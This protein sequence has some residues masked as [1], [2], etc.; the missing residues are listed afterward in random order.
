MVRCFTNWSFNN[1]FLRMIC[2][3]QFLLCFILIFNLLKHGSTLITHKL[4][5]CTTLIAIYGKLD[6]NTKLIAFDHF[7]NVWN[8]FLKYYSL[9]HSVILFRKKCFAH[10]RIVIFNF[11]FVEIHYPPRPSTRN[12]S[13]TDVCPKHFITSTN[14]GKPYSRKLV[15]KLV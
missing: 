3:F 9:K 7:T 13:Q 14:P 1:L 12:F 8:K 11:N 5:N 10:F 4:W 2:K 6:Y 15:R